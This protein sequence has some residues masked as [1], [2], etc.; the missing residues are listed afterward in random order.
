MVK[1]FCDVSTNFIFYRYYRIQSP[2]SDK[3]NNLQEI[4]PTYQRDYMHALESQYVNQFAV[5]VLYAL[6]AHYYYALLQ[7]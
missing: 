6:R 4:N 7:T 3:L 5:L 2:L 1:S